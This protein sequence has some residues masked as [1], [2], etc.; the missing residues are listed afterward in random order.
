MVYL[1]TPSSSC[2]RGTSPV[3]GGQGLPRCVAA[4]SPG[5]DGD[6]CD[7]GSTRP[8]PPMPPAP[9]PPI[10]CTAMAPAGT[11]M[12]L[13]YVCIC[14]NI[15]HACSSAMASTGTCDCGEGWRCRHAAAIPA[16]GGAC[17]LLSR[18]GARLT[19]AAAP[20]SSPLAVGDSILIFCC[21]HAHAA[22]QRL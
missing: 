15:L 2:P 8:A 10:C 5:F 17:A 9:A 6:S 11:C 22:F 16:P 18:A 20:V 12:R 21:L 1:Y 4:T 7:S 13:W 3:W 19:A 14:I